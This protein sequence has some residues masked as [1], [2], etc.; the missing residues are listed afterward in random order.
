MQVLPLAFGSAKTASASSPES[1][2]IKKQPSFVTFTPTGAVPIPCGCPTERVRSTEN[3]AVSITAMRSW[4]VTATY[5]RR[6]FGSTAMPS[7]WERCGPTW[8]SLIFWALAR[9]ITDTV[10]SDWFETRPRLPSAVI[11]AP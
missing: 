11:P 1:A 9:S 6:C 3:L 8:M 5:A 4:W 10:P 2:D 7:G